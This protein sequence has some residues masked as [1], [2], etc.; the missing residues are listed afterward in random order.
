MRKS[1]RL[2]TSSVRLGHAV[3][4]FWRGRARPRSPARGCRAAAA[5]PLSNVVSEA[6]LSAERLRDCLCDERWV[7]ERGQP[8]PEDAC[9]V[10]GD[11]RRRSFN[12]QPRLAC[13]SGPRQRHET[14]SFLESGQHLEQLVVAA[15]KRARRC[16]AGSSWRSSSAAGRRQLRVGKLD[17]ALGMSFSRCSPRSVTSS[18][19]SSAVERERITWPP[20]DD[21]ATRASGGRRLRCTPHRSEAASRYAGRT[22]TW[23]RPAARASVKRA[24]AAIAPGA[25][26]KAKKK[27]SP[28]VSTS[29][30]P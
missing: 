22:R 25:V 13:A 11:G 9:L 28:C 26:G 14:S 23:I 16:R 20:W 7:S 3:E 6:V 12:G 30:P 5:S 17:T 1:S 4:E 27:A 19:T 29:T 24:A 18:S 21:A 8:N 2:V 10:L 15:D